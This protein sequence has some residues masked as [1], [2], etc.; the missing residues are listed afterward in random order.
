[1]VRPVVAVVC[2]G[3]AVALLSAAGPGGLPSAVA[4]ETS[5]VA[6][7]TDRPDVQTAMAAA[8]GQ[9]SRV[10]ALSERTAESSTWANPD[11]S[12]YTEF[13]M[14]PIR[15]Q[16]VDGGWQDVDLTLVERDGVIGPK[17]SPVPFSL[18]GAGSTAVASGALGAGVA[19]VGW[20]RALPEPVLSGTT[21]TY[22]EV[23]PGVDLLVQALRTGFEVSFV[24]KSRPSAPL[25]LPLSLTL[26][27]LTASQSADGS[28]SLTDTRGREAGRGGTPWMYGSEKVPGTTVPAEQDK[29]ASVLSGAKPG[30]LSDLADTT[31]VSG[32]TTTRT[33][34]LSPDPA[35]LADPTVE[36]PV[37]VDPAYTFTVSSDTYVK[38]DVSTSQYAAVKLFIGMNG[39]GAK[40]RTYLHVDSIPSVLVGKYVDSASLQLYNSYSST[41]TTSL[42]P[43]YLW[44]VYPWT[45]QTVWSTQPG[46]IDVQSTSYFT[47]AGPGGGCG[48]AAYDNL[49][50]TA[51]MRG[52]AAGTVSTRDFAVTSTEASTYGWKEFHSVD[53]GSYPPRFAVT[54]W[55][56]PATPAKPEIAPA[57]FVTDTFRTNQ[58]QPILSARVT[59]PSGNLV[60]ARFEAYQGST[61]VWTGNGNTVTSGSVSKVTIPADSGLALNTSYV[62]RVWAVTGGATSKAWSDYIRFTID[63]T[64]PTAPTVASSDYP[65]GQ[66]ATTLA[67]GVFTFGGSSSDVDRFSYRFDS[68]PITTVEKTATST[69]VTIAPPGGWRTLNVR[70]LDAAGNTSGWTSY[71]FGATG[72]TAPNE[73]ATTLRFLTLDA[74]APT[75]ETGVTFQYRRSTTDPWTT[76]PAG[77]V[78]VAGNPVLAWPVATVSGSSQVSA[79]GQL[80]WDML[81]TLDADGPV[82]LQAVFTGATSP[83]TANQSLATLDQNAYGLSFAATDTVAGSVSL[84]TGNLAVAGSDAEVASFGG[85][86]A[87][88]RTFNSRQP[89][90]SPADGSAAIF[91]PGW[92][93]T[94]DSE[95]SDWAKAEDLG[96]QVRLTDADGGQWYFIRSGTSYLPV[97][98][99][100]LEGY[101]LSATGASKNYTFTLTDLDGGTVTI[102]EVTS[103]W[104]GTPS[105]ATP[106]PY[107]VTATQQAGVTGTSSYAYNTDGT[108]QMLFAP[109]SGVTCTPTSIVAGCRALAFTYVDADPGT[110]V[111]TRL[112]KVTLKT[113]TTNGSA[114]ATDLV[115]YTYD[116]T[117]D[118][119][120]QQ[121][122]DPRVGGSAGW[123]TTCG[124]PVQ[125]VTYGYDTAGRVSSVTPPGLAAVSIAYDGNGRFDSS[126]RTHNATHGGATLTTTVKYDVSI[127]ATSGGDDSH[128][129]LSNSRVAAW[130]Q[131]SVPVAAAAVFGPGDTV[132]STDLRDATVHAWTGDGRITN[133]AV[134]VGTGQD[135]W[136]SDATDYDTRGNT[137][138]SLSVGNRDRALNPATY[139]EQ[140]TDLGLTGATGAEIAAALSS[141]SVY[142]EDGIDVTDLYGPAHRVALPDGS[143]AVGRAHDQTEYG[144][145]D[146]PTVSPTTWTVDGPMHS[147]IRTTR[148]A[149]LSLSAVTLDETDVIETRIAYGLS[150]TD[151]PGWDLRTPMATTVENGTTDI[152]TQTRFD[153]NGNTIEQRQPTAAG[154]TSSPGT[155]VTQYYTTG[156]HNPATCTST[157]WFGQVC[158]TS[159][160]AQPGVSGLPSLV[161]TSYTYDALLRATTLTETVA[162][163]GGGTSTRTTTTAYRNGGASP[164]PDTV[165]ISGGV[166]QTVPVTSYD[167]DSPTGLQT[168]QAANGQ[169]QTTGYDDFG[170]AISFA[171][172]T[173]A[174]TRSTND[175]RDRVATVTWTK[176]DGTTTLA[177]QEFTY[178]SPTGSDRRGLLASV[179]D[180]DLGQVTATYDVSGALTSQELASGMQQTF[181]Y[182][183]TGDAVTTQ[184]LDSADAVLVGDAQVSDIHGRW[185]QQVLAGSHPGWTERAY[186][187]DPPVASRPCR[188]TAE[189]GA[190]PVHTRGTPTQTAP[191]PSP[192]PRPPTE[193][194]PRSPRRRG[195]RRWPTTVRI[196]SRQA[197]SRPARCM[198]R[199][200]VS[201]PSPRR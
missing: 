164:Q 50:I 78:T 190:S 189:P 99:A 149:S 132:S 134:Y 4:A 109:T 88:S 23:Q 150:G 41:C 142:A 98:D 166:G 200:A 26:N 197:A 169:T 123:A 82:Y 185:R 201:P 33:W 39:A 124:T 137:I 52:W 14:A 13:A 151:H 77:D 140:L 161:T 187:Y 119:R 32:S 133:T 176:T 120:L 191:Q 69:P 116:A 37:T 152:T 163:A 188:R 114:L 148:G 194:A 156:A 61:K 6:K 53:H 90:L 143:T 94:L 126:S 170:Q 83:T 179:T 108:P 45:S 44:R 54:Y 141:V 192:T 80:V 15:V 167:Y 68:G 113:T 25:S 106:Q 22:P 105:A 29:V 121:A 3:L 102:E 85:G 122:W 81:D 73:Q 48:G 157:V 178:T 146:Y 154:T 183:T 172:A 184:W 46:T 115:C 182:D 35:F 117:A 193:A 38:S 5:A 7:V 196:G 97:G 95:Q 159:P 129:D 199:G 62:L 174:I 36:F 8:R 130:G 11:G 110:A 180:S 40:A 2:A 56:Y 165:T 72:M 76:I 125:A 57:G 30:Q 17:V 173:G 24:V 49:D 59:S 87:V 20:V 28:V 58:S 84:Q 198:T 136:R 104:P 153:A 168:T 160:G 138:R 139:T 100:A 131:V 103:S 75:G 177:S 181:G 63:Q 66:F 158:T 64:A 186:A 111:A 144:S 42:A 70:A 34:Q 74:A 65:T 155:R 67:P 92:T 89:A 9:G 18:G 101:E 86:L 145:I 10:E 19:E 93:T 71:T 118:Y 79:P 135:G 55:D 195:R 31:A 16:G 107:R 96:A 128:P 60:Q 1:M 147:P 175:S 127:A 171:D 12:L 21:A 43:A 47:H 51:V 27:G 112:S 162:P 91:G